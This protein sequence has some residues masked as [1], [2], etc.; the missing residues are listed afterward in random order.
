MQS[1]AI[2]T[3]VVSS[4]LVQGEVYNIMCIKVCVRVLW[5]PPTIK[6]TTT[7]YNWNINS[8]VKH[9]Q[10]NKQTNKQEHIYADVLINLKASFRTQRHG[11][12]DICCFLSLGTS[13]AFYL[14]EHLVW[15]LRWFPYHDKNKKN[16]KAN[17]QTFDPIYHLTF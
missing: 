1:V 16:K 2:T 11:H 15:C 4:N 7:I 9:H 14:S 8:G 13:F 10:T 17:K 5:F 12:V 6:M 3:N